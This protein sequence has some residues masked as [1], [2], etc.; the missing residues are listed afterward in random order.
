MCLNSVSLAIVNLEVTTFE[1]LQLRFTFDQV[2]WQQY[3]K[4]INKSIFGATVSRSR[5]ECLVV[6]GE[7]E[8]KGKF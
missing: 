5:S 6:S 1:K 2:T 8:A 7:Q 3:S 4:H